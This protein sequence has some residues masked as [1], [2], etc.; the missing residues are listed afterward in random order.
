MRIC[1]PELASRIFRPRSFPIVFLQKQRRGS[2]WWNSLSLARDFRYP[3]ELISQPTQG[4]SELPDWTMLNTRSHL[5]MCTI[6]LKVHKCFCGS[7]FTTEARILS[8]HLIHSVNNWISIVRLFDFRLCDSMVY[9]SKKQIFA[10]SEK[11]LSLLD[12][13]VDCRVR[14]VCKVFAENFE[15]SKCLHSSGWSSGAQ[16]GVTKLGDNLLDSNDVN[17]R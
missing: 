2:S 15:G 8:M 13:S 10:P 6:H 1:R 11:P 9:F 4:N 14:P 12:R 3:S 5:W 16:F 17:F 7:F